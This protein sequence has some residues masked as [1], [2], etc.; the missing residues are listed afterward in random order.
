MPHK[1]SENFD[2]PSS[3]NPRN[4]KF[5]NNIY[6]QVLSVVDP[7][8]CKYKSFQNISIN[9]LHCSSSFFHRPAI[10]RKF[11]FYDII[12]SKVSQPA[13]NWVEWGSVV[14]T[15]GLTLSSFDFR[16]HFFIWL[17]FV[18]KT[19]QNIGES[20]ANLKILEKLENSVTSENNKKL[21]ANL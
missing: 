16:P 20:P 17:L 7:L 5:F 21:V 12:K 9:K 8:V 10:P 3:L 1:V 15:K 11:Y 2:N 18:E 13:N 6:W 19:P 4:W 14:I